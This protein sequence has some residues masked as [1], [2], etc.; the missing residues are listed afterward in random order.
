[1]IEIIHLTS[2][3]N[4]LFGANALLYLCVKLYFNIY[5]INEKESLKHYDE[6]VKHKACS[7]VLTYILYPRIMNVHCKCKNVHTLVQ[8]ETI[9]TFLCPVCAKFI[10]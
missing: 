5:N 8:F 10:I 6:A 4:I 2:L 1:M 9:R 3:K 7:N